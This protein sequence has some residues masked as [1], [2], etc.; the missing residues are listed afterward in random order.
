MRRNIKIIKKFPGTVAN[1]K[2]GLSSKQ[3]HHGS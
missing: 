1:G 2:R 3:V